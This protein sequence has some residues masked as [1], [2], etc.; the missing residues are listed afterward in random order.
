V[1]TD[2]R[3]AGINALMQHSPPETLFLAVVDLLSE[4]ADLIVERD[5]LYRLAITDPD[6]TI[7]EVEGLEPGR[8]A[9][10]CRAIDV[11][12]RASSLKAAARNLAEARRERDAILAVVVQP[13]T[14]ADGEHLYKVNLAWLDTVDTHEAGMAMVRRI[15][16]LAPAAGDNDERTD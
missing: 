4:R 13:W 16:G 3:I 15:A 9:A 2:E 10:D 8:T 6:L 12:N 14:R 11:W 5:R 7:D 1:L